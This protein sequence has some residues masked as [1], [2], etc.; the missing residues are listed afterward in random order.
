MTRLL[1]GLLVAGLAVGC[2]D[3]GANLNGIYEIT[4]HTIAENGCAEAPV[5]VTGD[6][7][8]FGC[9][10]RAPYFKVKTQSVFGQTFRSAIAC[11]TATECDDDDDPDTID[12]TGA[13]FDTEQDGKFVGVASAAFHGGASCG[14]SRAVFTLEETDTGVK[15]TRVESRLRADAASASLGEDDCFDLTDNPPPAAEMDCEEQEEVT[16]ITPTDG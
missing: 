3:D 16:G 15:I 11:D 13:L 2:G 1:I 8:C 9:I 12:L 5:E 4:S 7:D 10:L 14:F 6:L